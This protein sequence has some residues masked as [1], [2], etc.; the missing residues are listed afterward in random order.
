HQ[1]FAS[2]SRVLRLLTALI[3][4]LRINS[5]R[6][7]DNIDRACITIT[8]LAD[9]LVR[10]E[11]LSFRQAHEVAA[12]TAKAVVAADQSLASGGFAAFSTAFAEHV[13]RATLIDEEI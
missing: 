6:V 11:D 8:E 7:A 3:P 2:G 5:A 10:R 12:A 13:G 9:S 4:A 1:A